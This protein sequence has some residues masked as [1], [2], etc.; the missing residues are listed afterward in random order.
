MV[1]WQAWK[2]NNHIWS[3]TGESLSKRRQT[4]Q[5]TFI[6]DLRHSSLVYCRSC[7]L[8]VTHYVICCVNIE[9]WPVVF[10]FSFL[11]LQFVCLWDPPNKKLE[12]GQTELNVWSY[13]CLNAKL[14]RG[15]LHSFWSAL[16]KWWNCVCHPY[17]LN[18]KIISEPVKCMS[19]ERRLTG[20]CASIHIVKAN[21]LYINYLIRADWYVTFCV[22]IVL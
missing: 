16:A 13:Y 6:S 8:A 11:G 7:V 2:N 4:Y 19:I 12:D 18:E 21:V 22:F 3:V 9:I 10:F 17:L 15:L 20:S 14:C 5:N 1:I